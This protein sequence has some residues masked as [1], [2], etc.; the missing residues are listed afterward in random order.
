M[1][2]CAKVVC[3]VVLANGSNIVA[4]YWLVPSYVIIEKTFTA[5]SMHCLIPRSPFL[6]PMAV[7]IHDPAGQLAAEDAGTY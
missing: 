2:L 5:L 6:G 3:C 1:L 7:C 4:G